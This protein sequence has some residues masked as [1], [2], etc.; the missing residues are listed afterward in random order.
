VVQGQHSSTRTRQSLRSLTSIVE[1]VLPG[2]GVMEQ[3][4][5]TRAAWQFSLAHG[6]SICAGGELPGHRD[7]RLRDR[8]AVRVLSGVCSLSNFR[9]AR[10]RLYPLA[11]VAAEESGAGLGWRRRW[12]GDGAMAAPALSCRVGRKRELDRSFAGGLSGVCSLSNFRLASL[13]SKDEVD[14]L[15]SFL[16]TNKRCLRRRNHTYLFSARSRCDS[17]SIK[18]HRY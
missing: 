11:R 16:K 15:A 7:R 3:S 14:E 9:L 10:S 2:V 4:N 5:V 8:S 1:M 17:S 13:E 12:W 6:F 18:S